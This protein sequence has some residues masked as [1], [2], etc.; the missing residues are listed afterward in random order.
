[1]AFKSDTVMSTNDLENNF[2]LWFTKENDVVSG[3]TDPGSVKYD[4]KYILP[5]YESIYGI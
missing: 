5:F 2:T 1:M 3:E 4:F